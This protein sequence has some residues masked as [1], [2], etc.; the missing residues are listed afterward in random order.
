[1]FKYTPVSLIHVRFMLVYNHILKIIKYP[2]P[3]P[4][5]Y[6]LS[7]FISYSLFNQF[8]S[9]CH[10]KHSTRTALTKG[11]MASILLK[12]M[13]FLV[14][15]LLDSSIPFYS[16]S[17]ASLSFIFSPYIIKNAFLSFSGQPLPAKEVYF[18]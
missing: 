8:Q 14:L 15:I 2:P 5:N 7:S 3:L 16:L 4:P 6:C 1:M 9:K 18:T 17:L 13:V 10:L 12:P 11:T